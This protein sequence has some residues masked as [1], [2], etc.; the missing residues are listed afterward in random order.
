MKMVDPRKRKALPGI[1]KKPM[2]FTSMQM[3]VNARN[4]KKSKAVT[5]LKPIVDAAIMQAIPVKPVE[6]KVDPIIK[7]TPVEPVQAKDAPIIQ[8][9]PVKP[10]QVKVVHIMQATPVEPVQ[11]KDAPIIRAT[12]VKPVQAKKTT[13]MEMRLLMFGFMCG[14]I[15]MFKHRTSNLLYRLALSKYIDVLL[16]F[17]AILTVI[18][19]LVVLH[20]CC[21]CECDRKVVYGKQEKSRA[22]YRAIF[23]YF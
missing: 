21:S 22:F 3:L 1:A 10:V 16:A 9:T 5:N 19:F 4:L 20:S 17:L 18:S 23:W 15:P 13:W 14:I 12:P 7:A 11:A 8:A 2:G 6:A